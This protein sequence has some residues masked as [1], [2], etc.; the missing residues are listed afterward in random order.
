M[1]LSRILTE[2]ACKKQSKIQADLEEHTLEMLAHLRYPIEKVPLSLQQ[3]EN[4]SIPGGS[5]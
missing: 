1:N 3:S 5:T 4:K 2:A